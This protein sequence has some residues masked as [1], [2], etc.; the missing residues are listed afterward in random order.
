MVVLVRITPSNVERNAGAFSSKTLENAA[1]HL[2]AEGA[3]ILEDIIDPAS[4]L[5]ARDAFVRRYD[6]YLC[7]QTRD[8]ALQVGDRRVMI[9]VHLEPP[10]ERR[11]LI[12]NPWLL[13]VLRAA[14]EDEV[15]L[16]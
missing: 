10:F 14:F 5:D 9:T 12:A 7:G 4:I 16:G 11:E 13:S 8:D 3:L 6:R 1:R 15:V 2:R